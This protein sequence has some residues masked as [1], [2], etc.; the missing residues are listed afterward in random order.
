MMK[1]FPLWRYIDFY[2]FKDMLE[3]SSLFF[4]FRNTFYDAC[5]GEDNKFKQLMRKLNI[6]HRMER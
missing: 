3:T 2:K 5:E 4:A 6:M 1:N